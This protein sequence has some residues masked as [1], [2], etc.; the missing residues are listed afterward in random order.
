MYTCVRDAPNR[1]SHAS[2]KQ[3]VGGLFS[4]HLRDWAEM[5]SAAVT[6][7]IEESDRFEERP[8]KSMEYN[9]RMLRTC[10]ARITDILK[11]SLGTEV[12][13]YIRHFASRLNDRKTNVVW[14]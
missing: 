6:A 2:M 3:V 11:A 5:E 9:L 1:V 14:N 13:Y 10:A 12:N 4:G 7:L 8:T